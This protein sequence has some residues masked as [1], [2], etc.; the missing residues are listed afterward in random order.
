MFHAMYQLRYFVQ[1]GD[2]DVWSVSEGLSG[3]PGYDA[4]SAIDHGE[5]QR[6]AGSSLATSA[7]PKLNFACGFIFCR[8]YKGN[9][10]SVR[11]RVLH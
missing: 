1:R 3:H 11:P 9:L 8:T 10:S 2:L 7:A 4:T 6:D 5:N